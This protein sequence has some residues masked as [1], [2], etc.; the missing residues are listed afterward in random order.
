MVHKGMFKVK[1]NQQLI[2][3]K[4]KLIRIELRQL[5][6]EGNEVYASS[7]NIKIYCASKV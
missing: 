6:S 7:I 5:Q 4:K 2:T 3:T 1:L